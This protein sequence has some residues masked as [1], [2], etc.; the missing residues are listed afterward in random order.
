M[1]KN[2]QT[3][4]YE[5]LAWQPG[6]VPFRFNSGKMIGGHNR[7]GCIML[8]PVYDLVRGEAAGRGS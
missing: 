3:E 6:F 1:P 2:I 5:R 8:R 7:S 4:A